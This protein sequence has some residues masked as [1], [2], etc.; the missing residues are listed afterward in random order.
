MYLKKMQ[1]ICAELFSVPSCNIYNE[2][3]EKISGINIEKIK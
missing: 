2:F 1:L 3:P